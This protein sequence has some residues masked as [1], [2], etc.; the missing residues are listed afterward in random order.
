VHRAVL[1]ATDRAVTTQIG[2]RVYFFV[3]NRLLG[4]RTRDLEPVPEVEL[5]G[6]VTG[7]MPSPSGDRV[8]VITKGKSELA[9]ADRYSE[10]IAERI[11]L[12]GQPKSLRM[13]PTGR[14]VLVRAAEGDSI[15]V[16]G[17]GRNRI[18]GVVRSEWREDLPAVSPA[19]EIA[20]VQGKDVV[21]VDGATL[22]ETSRV[23]GGAADLW[24]FF[25]WDGF[26]P[27]VSNEERVDT[28]PGPMAPDTN[29][30]AGQLATQ[31]T[32]LFPPIAGTDTAP[33]PVP[34]AG[35]V[36]APPP[37]PVSPV[38]TGAATEFTLQFAAVRDESGARDLAKQ[39]RAGPGSAR[40]IA[41]TRVVTTQVAGSAVYRV[42][43]GPFRTRQEADAA[44][45]QTGKPYWVYA[46]AP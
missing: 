46:G 44:G 23:E 30:F 25:S 26:R 5:G 1:P 17:V 4:V 19:G 15:W 45:Q 2:D 34:P 7:I 22:Q 6:T 33:L 37:P 31:D 40:V 28:T 11:T 29:P 36:F 12:P 43:A 35:G 3:E 27:R 10:D 42:I 21:F 38:D 39:I 14:F 20:L 16:I 9:V 13:D 18:A 32:S 41:T 24:Y 8:Y